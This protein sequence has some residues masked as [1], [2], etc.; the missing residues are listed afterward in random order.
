MRWQTGRRSKNV[1][2]RRG[3]GG[4][5]FGFPGGGFRIPM[6]RSPRVGLP[7]G[8]RVGYP[9][10]ARSGG[11]GCL[12]LLLLALLFMVLFNIGPFGPSTDTSV[13]TAPP[14]S[15]SDSTSGAP[16]DELADFVSV[17]LADT[18]DTWNA[19]FSAAGRTYQ[20]PT[21]V[22]FSGYTQT[23]CGSGQSATGPFYCPL[24]QKLYIDLGFY[25]ELRTRFKAPG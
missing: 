11:I 20:E 1:E 25:D 10:S 21:L 24:D 8:M 16:E 2:D 7:G 15:W 13:S 3:S 12:G 9:R 6:P 4:G 14:A 19:I 5:G 17:V 23:A 18:E 22:L